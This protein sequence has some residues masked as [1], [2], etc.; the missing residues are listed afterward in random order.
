MNCFLNKR[1]VATALILTTLKAYAIGY[2]EI[3][4]KED[5]FKTLKKITLKQNEEIQI[6]V[7]KIGWKSCKVF[8]KEPMVGVNCY[9]TNDKSINYSCNGNESI[10]V[11]LSGNNYLIGLKI[12]CSY[13]K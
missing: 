5:N 13:K 2:I 1:I 9:V 10:E 4:E 11:D 7:K 6:D 12:N 3:R 8:S